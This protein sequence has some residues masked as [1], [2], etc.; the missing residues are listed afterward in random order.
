MRMHVCTTVNI[1]DSSHSFAR[2]RFA[3][4][5]VDTSI[6]RLTTFLAAC[7]SSPPI[8]H[9]DSFRDEYLLQ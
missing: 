9:H 4:R 8:S 7:L 2:L 3:L 1:V 6:H 5:V